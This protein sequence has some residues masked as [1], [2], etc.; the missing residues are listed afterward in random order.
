[1]FYNTDLFHFLLNR[2]Y[3]SPETEGCFLNSLVQYFGDN[4]GT[5]A[6]TMPLLQESTLPV[7]PTLTLPIVIIG[8]LF[9]NM[10]HV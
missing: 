10:F 5:N 3:S 2:N 4:L 7:D 6:K 8:E 1:M 9:S